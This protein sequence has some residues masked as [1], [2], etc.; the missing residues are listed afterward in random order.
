MIE[1]HSEITE[2]RKRGRYVQVTWRAI[3]LIR[4]VE[5]AVPAG[6]QLVGNVAIG[7]TAAQA[8]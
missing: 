1:L 5:E 3:G 4:G 7:Q 2:L 6:W 8:C